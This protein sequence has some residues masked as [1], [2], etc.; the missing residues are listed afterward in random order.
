MIAGNERAIKQLDVGGL[1]V[2]LHRLM[3]DTKFIRQ[4]KEEFIFGGFNKMIQGDGLD[5]KE[6]TAWE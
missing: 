2:T 1:I 5:L 6:V 3:T 4:V